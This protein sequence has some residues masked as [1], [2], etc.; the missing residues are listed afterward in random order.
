MLVFNL[1]SN[2][3]TILELRC[4][5]NSPIRAERIKKHVCSTY[6]PLSSI[7]KLVWQV[8]KLKMLLRFRKNNIILVK[9]IK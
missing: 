8:P 7:K 9:K 1:V 2:V 4:Y 3:R 5:P 6:A